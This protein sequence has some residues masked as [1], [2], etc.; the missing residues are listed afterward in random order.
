MAKKLAG[1]YAAAYESKT[2]ADNRRVYDEWAATYDADMARYQCV[3]TAVAADILAGY[4][5][6][7]NAAILD[8]GCGTGMGGEALYKLGF[9]TIDGADISPQMLSRARA[10]KIY[11]NLAV[12]DIVAGLDI[13]D[14]AY[15]AL[16]CA[17]AF[18]VGHLPPDCIAELARVVAP[19]GVMAITVNELVYDKEK[20][21]EAVRA[22]EERK[23]LKQL[24]AARREYVIET[25][26]RAW[27]LALR[28][29]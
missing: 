10:K 11:R 26:T 4:I 19:G 25:N 7:K 27:Y 17:G 1:C 18:T 3:S 15:G 14:N 2:P 5:R 22:L 13:A 28:I 20:F 29:L 9:A 21:P 16:L 23:I 8:A 24:S 6:D 12:G